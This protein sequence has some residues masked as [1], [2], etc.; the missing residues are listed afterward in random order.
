[1]RLR[2]RKRGGLLRVKGNYNP[3]SKNAEN[4]FASSETSKFSRILRRGVS[5]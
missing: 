5:S 4:I 1:M 3:K 2:I